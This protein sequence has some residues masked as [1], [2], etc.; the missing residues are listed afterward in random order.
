[1]VR[2]LWSNFC[3]LTNENDLDNR[4]G[5]TSADYLTRMWED[6]D[7]ERLDET[8]MAASQVICWQIWVHRNDVIHNRKQPDLESLK[9]HIRTY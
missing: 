9:L 4:L 7:G 6:K 1:M 2:D 3:P 8:K 5:W